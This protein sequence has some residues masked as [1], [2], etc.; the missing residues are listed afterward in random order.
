MVVADKVPAASQSSRGLHVV[1]SP[2]SSFPNPR[3]STTNDDSEINPLG[4]AL[5]GLCSRQ[6]EEEVRTEFPPV[7]SLGALCA[8]VGIAP[9]R[10]DLNYANELIRI[11]K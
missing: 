7:R 8:S 4:M 11:N 2:P 6:E 10:A 5:S 9:L 1:P 3:P